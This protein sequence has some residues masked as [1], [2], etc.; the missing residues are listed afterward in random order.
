MTPRGTPPPRCGSSSSTATATP[1]P[2]STPKTARRPW[3]SRHS[4]SRPARACGKCAASSSGS[5]PSC[6]SKSATPAASLAREAS[7][8]STAPPRSRPPAP[9]ATAPPPRHHLSRG[10]NRRVNACLNRIAITQLR[11]V[12]RARKIYD[13]ARQRGHTKNEAMRILKRHLSDVVYRQMMRDLD[14]RL[15]TQ[16]P[17][18]AQP[19]D[20]RASDVNDEVATAVATRRGSDLDGS[21]IPYV[22]PGAPGWRLAG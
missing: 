11:C 9:R 18:H 1:L 10:G 6:S 15:A 22:R 14:T 21:A 20:I 5:R 13:N 17:D 7:P 19:L 12:P 2:T 3:R 4:Q 8:A 16:P